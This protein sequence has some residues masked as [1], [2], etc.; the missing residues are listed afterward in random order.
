MGI[1]NNFKEQKQV[2]EEEQIY[3]D[4]VQRAFL[5]HYYNM[6]RKHISVMEWI[7]AGYCNKVPFLVKAD[8]DTFIDIFHLTSYLEMKQTDLHGTFYCS[9]TAHVKVE[10][11][12]GAKHSKWEITNK[13][14]P[15]NEFPT[16]CEGFGYVMDMKL[17]P[18]LYWCSMFQPSIWIDDVYMT[19]ILAKRLGIPRIPFQSGHSYYN[20]QPGREV[21]SIA[22]FI[23]LISL[24]NEFYPLTFQDMW[25]EAVTYS[26]QID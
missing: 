23:F 22:D 12:G 7:S 2:E 9:A 4:I 19:G 8:D 26:M 24:Y 17:A 20:L 18:Y 21:G 25:R 6:T 10:R 5:E 1:S 3:G 14:Y 11:P 16:Y 15:E 13:E